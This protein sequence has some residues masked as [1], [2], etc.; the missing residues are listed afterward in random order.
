MGGKVGLR[1]L[2]HSFLPDLP[3]LLGI[4]VKISIEV[5]WVSNLGSGSGKSPLF[6]Q[7]GLHVFI[8]TLLF[9]K[10]VSNLRAGI[11]SCF[12]HCCVPLT[13]CLAHSSCSIT[14]VEE[15]NISFGLELLMD[16]LEPSQTPA[17]PSQVELMAREINSLT[18]TM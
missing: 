10:N 14:I 4:W 12:V 1:G 7:N 11:S 13:Q 16:S 3:K 9:H 15:V 18:L 6:R 2:Q 17:L 5:S 8:I